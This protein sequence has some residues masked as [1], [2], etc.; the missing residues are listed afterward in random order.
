[1]IVIEDPHLL[2]FPSEHA[3]VPL[4]ICSPKCSATARLPGNC[5][6]MLRAELRHAE[7]ITPIRQRLSVLAQATPGIMPGCSGK[8]EG[9]LGQDSC[10]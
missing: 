3:I 5:K 4:C 6:G 10:E 9:R 8:G 1:M 7:S 2:P